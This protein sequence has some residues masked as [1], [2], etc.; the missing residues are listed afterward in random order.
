MHDH[1]GLT[2]NI[3]ANLSLIRRNIENAARRSGRDPVDITLV[4]VTKTV[5]TDAIRAAISC[6]VKVVGESRV[7]EAME[8]LRLVGPAVEWHLIG[9]LQKNKVKYILD[10]FS[11]VHSVDSYELAAEIGRQ[12]AQKGKTMPVLLQV[13]IGEEKSKHGVAPLDAADTAK[14]VAGLDGIRLCGL[15]AI[16]PFADDPES[17][18]PYFRR[19]LEIKCGLEGLRLEKGTFDVLSFGMT[20]DYEVAVEEG[21]THLRIG[22]G[23]FGE[24]QN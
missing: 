15:M 18:R 13:N 11:L 1:N 8:K 21:A 16:P 12:A 22:T 5:G 23:I 3:A 19:V 24:R 17:S 20:G 14:R 9:H 10:S 4:A 2:E 7:Q 6:G